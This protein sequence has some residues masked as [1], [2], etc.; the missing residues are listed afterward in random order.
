MSQ[1]GPESETPRNRPAVPLTYSAEGLLDS[2]LAE[3]RS[4]AE[5]RAFAGSWVSLAALQF[6]SRS[7]EIEARVRES[8]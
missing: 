8:A 7:E 3:L 2:Q 6:S 1:K 5:S 4:G